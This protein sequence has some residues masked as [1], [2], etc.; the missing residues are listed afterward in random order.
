M[1]K[2]QIVAR[3]KNEYPTLKIGDDE[4]GYTNLSSA[5]YEKTISQWADNELAAEAAKIEAD[6][7]KAA[8][9]AKLGALGITVEDLKAI[10]L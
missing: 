7:V 6:S 4:R 3:L 8:A 1:T 5:E 10:G 2:A 9:Q